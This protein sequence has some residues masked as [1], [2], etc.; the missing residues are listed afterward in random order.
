MVLSVRCLLHKP[1][2]Q[3]QTLSNPREWDMAVKE[4]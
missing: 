1:E 3:L 2:D 4:P